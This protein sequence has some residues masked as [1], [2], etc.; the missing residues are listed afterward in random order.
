MQKTFEIVPRRG[1]WDV[2]HNQVG[3][4]MCP[5]KREAIRLALALGRMQIRMGD[6]AQI[7]VRGAD[8]ALTAQRRL[9]ASGETRSFAP[10]GG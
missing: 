3:Y 4:R 9:S 6:E 7:S 5:Q 8:G 2:V 10:K 1:A